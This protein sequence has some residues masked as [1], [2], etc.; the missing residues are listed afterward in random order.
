MIPRYEPVLEPALEI[1]APAETGFRPRALEPLGPEAIGG[2][3]FVED[4][5]GFIDSTYGRVIAALRQ[6]EYPPHLA[7]L[8]RPRRDRCRWSIS[9]ASKIWRR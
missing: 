6:P 3:V 4:P 7:D 5:G 2:F 1:P 8:A 9:A